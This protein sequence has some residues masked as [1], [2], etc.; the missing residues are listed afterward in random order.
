M[1]IS[2]FSTEIVVK[3]FEHLQRELSGARWRTII[4]LL[5]S[6]ALALLWLGTMLGYAVRLLPAF[7]LY[8]FLPLALNA[9]AWMVWMLPSGLIP[10]SGRGRSTV[11]FPDESL[12]PTEIRAFL[13]RTAYMEYSLRRRAR[14]DRLISQFVVLQVVAMS[15]VTAWLLYIIR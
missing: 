15:T 10:L 5:G 12:A 4:I 6:T 11:P 8:L 9:L 2:A 1:E 14:V 3:E 13:D 7:R